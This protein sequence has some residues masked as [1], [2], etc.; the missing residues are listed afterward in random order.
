MPNKRTDDGVVYLLTCLVSGKQYVGQTWDYNR[1]MRSYRYGRSQCQRAIHAA[2]RKYGWNNFTAV[3]IVQGI[4]TQ[5]WLSKIETA[6]IK[7]FNTLAPNGYNLTTGGEGGKPCAETRKR[8]SASQKGIPK[9]PKSDEHREKLRMSLKGRPRPPEVVAKVKSALLSPEVNA[10]LRTS[11][12]GANS[13][14]EVKARRSAGQKGRTISPE[15]RA[16]IAASLRGRKL[17]P[18]HVE[19][20]AAGNRGRKRSPAARANMRAA[21]QMRFARE[22]AAVKTATASLL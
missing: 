10:K 8:I 21:Q 9:G 14:P 11:L 16:K 22:S 17:S 20:A 7:A 3:K 18:K 12:L 6:Y 2:I 4:Q 5:E 13:K 19:N 15:H 1:R